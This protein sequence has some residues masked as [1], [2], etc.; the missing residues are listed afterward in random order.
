[1]QKNKD[2]DWFFSVIFLIKESCNQSK[3]ETQMVTLN[4]LI[5]SGVSFPSIDH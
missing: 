3:L 1:M 4:Q 5:V 2:F